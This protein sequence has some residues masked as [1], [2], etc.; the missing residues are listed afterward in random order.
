MEA[1]SIAGLAL[2][3]A[4]AAGPG[5]GQVSG[6]AEADSAQ[7]PGPMEYLQVWGEALDD[8]ILGSAQERHKASLA[9]QLKRQQQRLLREH[10]QAEM[11]RFRAEREAAVAEQLRQQSEQEAARS[12]A[13]ERQLEEQRKASEQETQEPT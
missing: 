4:L 8:A 13:L 12:E 7:L 10:Q 6:Q 1:R 5:I 2:I 9:Q 11:E 3:A